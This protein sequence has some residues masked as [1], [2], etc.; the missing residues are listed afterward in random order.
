MI[1]FVQRSIVAFAQNPITADSPFQANYISGLNVGQSYVNL[2]NTGANGASQ[3]GPGFGPVGNLCI[4]V[5][6]FTTDEQMATCCSCLVT[7]NGLKRLRAYEDLIQNSLT[8]QE[9]T[10]ALSAN[11]GGLVVKTV[12]TLAG[13][14]GNSTNCTNSAA[15]LTATGTNIVGGYIAFAT[16]IHS[17]PATAV[18][19]PGV[20]ASITETAFVPSTLSPQEIASLNTRCT[21]IIGNGTG[22][23]ICGTCQVG[24]LGSVKF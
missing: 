21:A 7:P 23:G 17:A 9:L 16:H 3:F 4:N 18:G 24:A 1:R 12:A 19:N 5:Y 8:A 6:A 14:N 11:A 15:Q 10:L 20:A 13:G 2:I 22:A